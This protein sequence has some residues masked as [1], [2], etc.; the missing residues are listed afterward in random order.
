MTND[1]PFTNWTDYF[2]TLLKVFSTEFYSE[3]Y[4]LY[5][6]FCEEMGK[7]SD[8]T[9]MFDLLERFQT[10][11]WAQEGLDGL[12]DTVIKGPRYSYEHVSYFEPVV[13]KMI[14]RGAV[15]NFNRIFTP[16][17]NEDE[18]KKKNGFEE[19]SYGFNSR[20]Q[21]LILFDKLGVE[22]PSVIVNAVPVYWEDLIDWDTKRQMGDY[23]TAFYSGVKY[24]MVPQSELYGQSE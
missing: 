5:A 3:T 4:P 21:L 15:V 19:E 11:E 23:M 7:E 12:I 16:H 13:K 9:I 14:D 8:V 10:Q 17:L 22:L 24:Y 6:D 18:Q 2:K 1:Y 20:G